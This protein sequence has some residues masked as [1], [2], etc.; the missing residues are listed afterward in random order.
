[1]GGDTRQY[2]DGKVS[3]GREG[4]MLGPRVT[5]RVV[6]KNGPAFLLVE[7]VPHT[8]AQSLELSL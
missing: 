7:L 1:M 3:E 4:T 2:D 5:L 6:R 8:L